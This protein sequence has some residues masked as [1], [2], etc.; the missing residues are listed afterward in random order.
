[1]RL[2]VPINMARELL[3]PRLPEFLAA[4]PQLELLL[5]ATDRRVDLLRDGFDCVLRIGSL[6]D[7]GL[8]ARRLGTLPMVNCVSPSYLSKYGVPRGLADL[9][10]HLL[11][12]YSVRLGGSSAASFEYRAAGRYLQR[13]MRSLITVNNTDAYRA[14]CLAGLGIIQAPRLGLRAAL[15]SG[16]LVEVLP[17]LA[18]EEMPVSIVHTRNVPK[19]VRAVMSW[20]ARQLEPHVA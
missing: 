15:A 19:R 10:A 12:N 4:H 11:V 3:I 8:L 7:S 18:S 2:D 14:A 20:L 1:V 5:S 9:D 17:E 6:E 13:P 16:E